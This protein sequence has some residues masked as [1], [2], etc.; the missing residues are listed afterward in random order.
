MAT[1][2][3]YS[4]EPT[5]RFQGPGAS[6]EGPWYEKTWVLV[7]SLL[8]C[9]PAGLVFVWMNKQF[10]QKTKVTITGVVAVLAV[11]GGIS[12]AMSPPEETNE[13]SRTTTTEAPT[14][15][16]E[17]T[18][19]KATPTTTAA[20]TTTKPPTT[21]TTAPPTTT[22]PPGPTLTPSQEQAIRAAQSYLDFTA[23]S[24]QG[25]IDQLS[26]EYGNQFS[27]EDATFAV[28]SSNTDWNAQAVKSAQ[29]YLEFSAFSCQGLIDQLSSEYGSQFTVEQATHGARQPPTAS[30]SSST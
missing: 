13:V 23:F 21:T 18:T 4:G 14:T 27:V 24:R 2:P 26:S 10:T 28:D 15:T 7:V 20:P 29:S 1:G 3:F 5:P 22:E 9:F 12:S 6:E 30:S 16:A 19:T 25:L 17:P 11:I 8:F